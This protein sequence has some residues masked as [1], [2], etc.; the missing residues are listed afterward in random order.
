M[1]G[2]LV[3]APCFSREKLDFSP[4]EKW[5]ILKWALAPGIHDPSAEARDQGPPFS[6]SA[7]ALLPPHE[8]GGSTQ[9]PNPVSRK[10]RRMTLCAF[11]NDLLR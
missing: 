2:F 4:A 5:P 9:K 1:V 10:L 11:R 3:E 8:C 7:K 6:R